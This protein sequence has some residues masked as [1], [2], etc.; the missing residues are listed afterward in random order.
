MA[1]N[2]Y[3]LDYKKVH[4][5]LGKPKKN[6]Y[7]E[8]VGQYNTP[9]FTLSQ[10]NFRILSATYHAYQSGPRLSWSSSASSIVAAQD[11]I[12]KLVIV[13]DTNMPNWSTI[14]NIVSVSANDH[15]II[16]DRELSFNPIT[17]VDVEVIFSFVPC[18]NNY[19][20]VELSGTIFSYRLIAHT[21]ANEYDFSIANDWSEYKNYRRSNSDKYI[22]KI[23]SIGIKNAVPQTFN[24]SDKI[25][26]WYISICCLDNTSYDRS[27][28]LPVIYES[29]IPLT[30]NNDGLVISHTVD[31]R[32]IE[33][34][35]R[36]LPMYS[37]EEA[38][39]IVQTAKPSIDFSGAPYYLTS[40]VEMQNDLF[41]YWMKYNNY[42]MTPVLVRLHSV[43]WPHSYKY[44]N[45]R[46]ETSTRCTILRS[47]YLNWNSEQYT[48]MVPAIEQISAENIHNGARN[49]YYPGVPE[50]GPENAYN[51]LLDIPGETNPHRKSIYSFRYSACGQLCKQ[52]DTGREGRKWIHLGV[53]LYPMTLND[54]WSDHPYFNG[55]RVPSTRTGKWTVPQDLDYYTN[56]IYSVISTYDD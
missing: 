5:T 22:I 19:F 6:Q 17:T 30:E 29:S 50:W 32:I 7:G 10:W 23:P 1:D 42:Y 36:V 16:L 38:W 25:D 43:K 55:S 27:R 53:A 45:I 3:Q 37:D 26:S 56:T 51:E 11:W 48:I 39:Q 14:A 47:V 21:K 31:R 24:D 18:T 33:P 9:P 15:Y 52:G 40:P 41:Y 8:E 20:V 44:K 4:N 12:G 2:G 28:E 34:E 46:F 13:T 35:E 54:R 49:M